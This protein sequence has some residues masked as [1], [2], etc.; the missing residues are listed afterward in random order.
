VVGRARAGYVREVETDVAMTTVRVAATSGSVRVIAEVRADVDVPDSVEYSVHDSM[1]TVSS[2]SR[3]VT[4]RVPEGT[5]LVIGSASGRVEVIGRAGSVAVVTSS[6][7]VSVDTARSVDIRTTS[8]RVTVDV[9]DESCRVLTK[10]GRVDI[11]RCGAAHLTASSGKITL[12]AA[13][14]PVHAHCVSGRID[15][16]TTS[17]QDVEAETVSGR[18]R[19]RMPADVRPWIVHRNDTEPAPERC[20]CVVTARSVSGRIDVVAA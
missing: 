7:R 2:G 11:G 5:D 13:S 19:V 12:T 4:V 18:I 8:G 9:A 3:R 17:A 15:V 14:G 1:T 16:A 20:D 6:G 10:S